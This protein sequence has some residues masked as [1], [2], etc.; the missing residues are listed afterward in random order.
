M[1]DIEATITSESLILEN[2]SSGSKILIIV[3][4]DTIPSGTILYDKN[5]PIGKKFNGSIIISGQL[6]NQ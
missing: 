6:L 1:A 3:N 5:V 4:P 2:I